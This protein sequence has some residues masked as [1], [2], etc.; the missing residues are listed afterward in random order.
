MGCD[1]NTQVPG[2]TKET[3]LFDSVFEQKFKVIYR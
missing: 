2:Q 3:N 1:D